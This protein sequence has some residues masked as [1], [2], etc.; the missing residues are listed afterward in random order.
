M[1]QMAWINSNIKSNCLSARG[2]S[3]HHTSGKCFLLTDRGTDMGE[4]MTSAAEVNLNC[5]LNTGINI[6][7]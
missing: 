7:I 6:S 1:A 5:G 2:Q 3:V 4:N